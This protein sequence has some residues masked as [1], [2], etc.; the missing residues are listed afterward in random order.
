MTKPMTKGSERNASHANQ[1]NRQMH[2]PQLSDAQIEVVINTALNGYP[3]TPLPVGF[4]QRVK[5]RL[6]H[7]NTPSTASPVS[8]SVTHQGPGEYWRLNLAELTLVVFFTVFFGSIV[9]SLL[10]MIA[11]PNIAIPN[12]VFLEQWF[13]TEQFSTHIGWALAAVAIAVCQ[14]GALAL[15]SLW[16]WD[17][18]MTPTATSTH[19]ESRQHVALDI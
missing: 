1:Q 14:A 16:W 9:L 2:H 7:Q 12:T 5:M 6:S 11:I 4:A 15:W 8:P 3:K 17:R 18:S 19:P 10:S 13:T